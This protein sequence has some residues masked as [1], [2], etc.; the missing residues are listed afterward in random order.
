MCVEKE[1]KIDKI[2]GLLTD[3]RTLLEN[4]QFEVKPRPNPIF[5]TGDIVK[6]D[7]GCGVGDGLYHAVES[8]NWCS[9]KYMV[10]LFDL[11]ATYDD[12]F[13]KI[14]RPAK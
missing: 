7:V 4:P 2:I 11:S 10:K 12:A 1:S 13:L 6:F 5:K 14:V 9:G 8:V 3:V